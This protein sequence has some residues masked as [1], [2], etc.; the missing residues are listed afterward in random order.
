MFD[1]VQSVE[2]RPL[3]VAAL[4]NDEDKPTVFIDGGMHAR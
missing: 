4:G 3:V 2:G 1:F